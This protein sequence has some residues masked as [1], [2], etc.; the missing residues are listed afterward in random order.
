VDDGE[1]LLRAICAQPGEDL[2][3][4]AYAEW[5]EETGTDP[6]RVRFI[7]IQVRLEKDEDPDSGG[8]LTDPERRKEL[9]A[10][11]QDLLNRHG[12]QWGQPVIALGAVDVAYS[13]GFPEQITIDAEAFQKNAEKIFAAAPVRGIKVNRMGTLQDVVRFAASP[14]LARLNSLTLSN[15]DNT[16]PLWN[17]EDGP[18]VAQA[19]AASPHLRGLTHLNISLGHIGNEG[20]RSLAASQNLSGLTHLDLGRNE[21]GPEGVWAIAGSLHL[22]SLKHLDLRENA[23]GD[24]TI[25]PITTSANFRGLRSLNLSA[26]NISQDGIRTIAAARNL[27][28]LSDLN[29]SGNG[30]GD[31]IADAVA[32]ALAGSSALTPSA[33][34]SALWSIGYH[35]LARQ[36]LAEDGQHAGRG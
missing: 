10:E 19:L 23:I 35:R 32:M 27:G 36:A 15:W 21:I 34:A 26:A 30:M 13:R 5:L 17:P 3:R 7:R 22:R 31:G 33:K 18:A 12:G 25:H 8:K 16:R 20:L 1:A 4:L 24:A 6:D 2:P 28:S 11:A 29:L 14:H 9:E